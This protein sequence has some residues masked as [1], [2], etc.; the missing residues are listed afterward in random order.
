VSGVTDSV[1]VF[2]NER[3]I[4]YDL[5]PDHPLHQDRILLHYELSK[6]LGVL[7]GPGVSEPKFEPATDEQLALIHSKEYIEQIRSLSTQKNYSVL[8]TGDTSAFPGAYDVARLLVGGTLAAV[9]SVMKSKVDH[10]WNP[11]GGLHHAHTDRA[12]GFCIFNDVAIACRYLQKHYGVKRILYLDIDVHHGDGVQE[13]FF[14]DP[15]VLTLSIHQTGRT[16][17]P[18]S[19]FSNE[20]GEGE[21]LGYSVNVPL[22]PYTNNEQYL[23]AFEAIVP[24]IIEAF[25]PEVIVMQN[26]VDTHYQDE[27]GN[28][29][30]TTHAFD[31]ISSRVHELAHRLVNGRLVAVGGGGYSYYSVPR[32]W[33]VILANLIGVTVADTIPE[34]WR[35]LFTNVTGLEAPTHLHDQERPSLSQM[36]QDRIGRLVQESVTRTR[37]L[38][39]PLLG[40]EK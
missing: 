32:C 31:S 29:I 5:G 24:P 28:L 22:P 38:I 18:D 36:N 10:S 27:L 21:G 35:A 23:E 14:D 2:Y 6:A 4:D 26:G 40:I 7:Q 12:A 30:L 3:F 25:H 17:Y 11:G 16:I 19:G 34:E 37:D 15:S 13:L 20:I 33:T 1:A 8:D 9:D 39:F